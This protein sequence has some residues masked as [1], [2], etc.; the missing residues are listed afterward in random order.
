MPDRTWIAARA[1]DLRR[2]PTDAERRLWRSLR[3]RGFTG[4]K[5][6]R[7]VPIGSYIADFVCLDA[8]LVIEVDG[9]QHLEEQRVHDVARDAW[10]RE[11]GFRVL[12]FWDTEVLTE[13]DEVDEAIWQAL[14]SNGPPDDP[15]PHPNPPP[16]G[17]RGPEAGE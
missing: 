17:G 11:Q 3:L 13:P 1:R 6:R 7:Q 2:E 16:R 10:F 4:H 15:A 12:R 8:R 5:F 9:S 14:Q